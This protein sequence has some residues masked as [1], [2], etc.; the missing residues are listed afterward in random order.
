[1]KLLSK[2][3]IWKPVLKAGSFAAIN[4]FA[5]IG[6][7][8]FTIPL[9]INYLGQ[10]KYGL[11]ITISSLA[12]Y[13]MLL[14]F[15][16]SSAMVNKLTKFYTIN[17]TRSADNYIIANLAFFGIMSIIVIGILS[18]IIP[19]I[20]WVSLMKLKAVTNIDEVSQV[21]FFCF[22]MFLLQLSTMIIL[23]VPYAMQTGSLTEGYLLLGNIISVVG[24]VLS[25]REN[26]GLLTLIL[27]LTSSTIITSIT[28]M[29][30]LLYFKK[31]RIHFIKFNTIKSVFLDLYKTGIDFIVIQASGIIV[32]GLQFSIL[33]Y[34]HGAESVAPYGIMFQILLA[35][36]IP[37]TVLQQPLW[38][39]FVELHHQSRHKE[40]GYA[41]NKYIKAALLYSIAISLI[42]IC[43]LPFI[44][45]YFIKQQIFIPIG[46]R[47]GFSIWA[48]MGLIFGGGV[49]ASLLAMNLTRQAAIISIIQV[50][51]FIICSLL[52]VPQYGA[53][54]MITSI[55]LMY[56]IT[57]PIIYRLLKSK[58]F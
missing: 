17:D 25:V 14:D 51:I 36:Q 2:N 4:K 56:F 3:S 30:H 1:M 58:V 23:K 55:V 29:L 27:F 11:W 22:F 39:K 8:L 42:F 40:I 45:P 16:I 7:R 38:S 10:E 9:T 53:V 47:I 32:L 44:F 46:L 21:I 54:G 48:G 24:I 31:I 19:A 37:F 26:L 41:I 28:L 20:D 12:G 35:I 5:N 6:I 13:I 57:A 50:I 49:G 15:G 43:L 34:Y 18:I 52:L 33:A